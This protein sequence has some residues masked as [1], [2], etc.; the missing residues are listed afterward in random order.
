MPDWL[1]APAFEWWPAL[2]WWCVVL[3]SFAL[4]AAT[5]WLIK[6]RRTEAKLQR[7]SGQSSA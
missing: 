6:S 7:A 3:L 4:G 2:P 5:G 1:T